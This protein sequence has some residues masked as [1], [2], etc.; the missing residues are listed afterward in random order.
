MALDPTAFLLM[1]YGLILEIH[2][3]II[4]L[5]NFKRLNLQDMDAIGRVQV[6]LRHNKLRFQEV[7]GG[8]VKI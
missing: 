4:T 8:E 3:N 7:Y 6:H 2:D 5:E 1:G